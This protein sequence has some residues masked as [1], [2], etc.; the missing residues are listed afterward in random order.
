MDEERV[1]FL[2]AATLFAL[3]LI[4]GAMIGGLFIAAGLVL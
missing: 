3:A 4:F 1:F 2:V